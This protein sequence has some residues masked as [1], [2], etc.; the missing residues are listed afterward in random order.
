[1]LVDDEADVTGAPDGGVPVAVAV[2]SM[3]PAFTSACAIVRVAEHVVEPPGTNDNDAHVIDDKP[4]RGSLIA[5]P[6]NVTLPVF[7]TKNEKVW[8]SP[9]DAPDGLVSVEIATVLT[10]LIDFV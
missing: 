1:M 8:V 6:L 7:V 5:T 4:M 3:V 9:N 2:L 10:R